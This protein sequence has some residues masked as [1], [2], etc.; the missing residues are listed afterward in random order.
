MVSS[1][2]ANPAFNGK[3]IVEITRQ[4]RGRSDLKNQIEQIMEMYAA[5]GAAMVYHKMDERD[6]Q[7]IMREPWTMVASDSGVRRFGEGVP[8]PRGYGDN[9]RVL[10][11][12]VREQKVISLEEAVRKMSS[13]PARHFG[14]ADRGVIANGH[15]ADIVIFDPATVSDVATYEKPHQFATGFAH[16]LVNGVPVIRAGETTGAR[17]GRVLR[18][19]ASGSSAR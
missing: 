14:F 12:Y 5:R 15:A 13:L 2:A 10:G 16:V 4:A 7:R 18:G 3:S 19:R 6:V 9:A 11:R 1:Y 17:P 8:H